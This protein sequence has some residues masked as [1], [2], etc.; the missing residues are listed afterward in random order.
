MK[1]PL[2][3][4]L[5]WTTLGVVIWF[6]TDSFPELEEGYPGPAL[7]P[8]V[9]AIGLLLAGIWLTVSA[10][11]QRS[12]QAADASFQFDS[13]SVIRLVIGVVLVICFPWVR[14][15]FGVPVALGLLIFGMAYI[16]KPHLLTALGSAVIG[17]LSIYSL[18]TY[19]LG[20]PL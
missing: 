10:W 13:A 7:F 6:Y 14:D 5:F 11:M 16:L 3:F 12:H 20:V 17:A 4:G 9:I 8:R 15:W 2:L 18:F 19:L 1:T